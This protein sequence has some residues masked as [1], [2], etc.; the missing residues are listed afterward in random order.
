MVCECTL[1]QRDLQ[2]DIYKDK[3]L[4]LAFEYKEEIIRVY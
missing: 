1:K 3:N 4:C 2:H